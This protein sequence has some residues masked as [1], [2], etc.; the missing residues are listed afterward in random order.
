MRA[1]TLMHILLVITILVLR[2]ECVSTFSFYG[3]QQ[4]RQPPP[5][6]QQQQQ[7][8][9][10]RARWSNAAST[11]VYNNRPVTN[12]NQNAN[13][14]G[15]CIVPQNITLDVLYEDSDVLVINKPSGMV[16][17]FVSGAVESAVVFY[18]NATAAAASSSSSN[19]DNN[20]NNDDNNNNNT[21][22]TSPSNIVYNSSSWPWKSQ[23]SFEGIVH[24]IDKET[25]GILVVGKHPLAARALHASFQERRVHKTYLAIAVGLPI[26]PQ[27]TTTTTNTTSNNDINN[28][29]NNSVLSSS[30]SSLPL[31]VLPIIQPHQKRLCKE[32]KNCG[33]DFQ[34]A[35]ELIQ[36][37][38]ADPNAAC[39]SAAISVCKRAGQRDDAL[40]LFDSMTA[41]GVTPTTKCFKKAISLCAKSAPPLYEKAVELVGYMEECHL[42][43]HPHCVSSAISA[44]GSAGQVEAALELLRLVLE[45]QQ[46]TIIM[47]QEEDTA[48]D[49]IV[50]CFQAAIRACERC[51][52]T[53]SGLALKDQLRAMTGEDDDDDDEPTVV[54]SRAEVLQALNAE[55]AVDA[56]IGKLTG[57]RLMG[58][59]PE[60]QG[61]RA[62]RSFVSPLAYDG[63][64]SLNRVVIETGRTHQIRVH[65]GSVLGCPLAGDRLYNRDDPI[66]KRAERCML[67][68]TELTLPHPIITG[69]MLTI[70][71][72]PPP[73]FAALAD[74]IRD[75]TVQ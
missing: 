19:H 47:E 1:L 59:L 18:L 32:I 56:P 25:S 50:G 68:A 72:P 36:D 66:K 30:S 55:I 27:P 14:P 22:T 8:Q 45:K 31:H 75:A 67:H 74:A 26:Q 20:N 49:G 57:S 15:R 63:T 54:Y 21:P 2:I 9:Q 4:H 46:Q 48:E 58:I 69:S 60:S 33:R 61:G 12:Q 7:Q 17:Q 73:D 70:S 43:L 71:C 11:R 35:L 29:N 53:D 37:P 28:N 23:N 52:A 39:F 34:K 13:G 41:R 5:R 51:G 16:M 64:L 44:C 62:A 10:Q 40:L 3:S 65:M 24:R 38:S 42:P 6:Q